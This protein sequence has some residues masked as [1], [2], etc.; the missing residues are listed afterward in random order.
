MK[1]PLFIHKYFKLFIKTHENSNVHICHKYMTSRYLM[2]KITWKYK[3][4][5]NINI[6]DPYSL[7]NLFRVFY[8]RLKSS[9]FAE[10]ANLKKPRYLPLRQI[11]LGILRR[12][13]PATDS[14]VRFLFGWYF[15]DLSVPVAKR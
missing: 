4:Y 3:D 6:F 9:D 8:Y 12:H 2:Y 13:F 10:L 14:D 1:S 15:A 11:R 7:I 5:L